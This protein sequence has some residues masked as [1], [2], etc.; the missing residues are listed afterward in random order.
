MVLTLKITLLGSEPLVWRR[1]AIPA[2]F[3]FYQLH[4]SIQA[5]FGWENSHLFQFGKGGLQDRKGIGIPYD[6][7]P[8]ADARNIDV[9]KHFKKPGD[10]LVY[11]YDFG[12]HWQH[13]VV[14]ESIEKEELHTAF[15][16]E[17]KNE[18]PPENVGGCHGYKQML[19]CF[20]YGTEEEKKEYRDWL[21]MRPDENW[22]PE[23][24]NMREISK[25][26]ALL[27]H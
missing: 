5:V 17:G 14:L 13:S 2:T 21:G 3:N 24:I 23:Y 16:T 19:H 1:I 9:K 20:L 26:L 22:D 18:C 25:R 4:M 8:I 15:C 11:V 7:N 27:S 12:D 6:D 10:S